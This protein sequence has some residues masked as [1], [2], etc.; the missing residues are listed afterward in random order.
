MRI[1][2]FQFVF[3]VERIGVV[4]NPGLRISAWWEIGRK[5]YRKGRQLFAS[6]KEMAWRLSNPGVNAAQPDTPT[7]RL[8]RSMTI[9]MTWPQ[10]CRSLVNLNR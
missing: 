2:Q 9:A 10:R 5:A 3:I 4:V 7:M 6:R 1:A 8:V